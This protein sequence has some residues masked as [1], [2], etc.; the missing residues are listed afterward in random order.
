MSTDRPTP[1]MPS[2]P[3]VLQTIEQATQRVVTSDDFVTRLAQAIVAQQRSLPVNTAYSELGVARSSHH[4]DFGS[5]VVC[6]PQPTIHGHLLVL[7][8]VPVQHGLNVLLTLHEIQPADDEPRAEGV[9]LQRY[10]QSLV[11]DERA[12]DLTSRRYFDF[13]SFAPVEAQALREELSRQLQT[14]S[15]TR[16][17]FLYVNVLQKPSAVH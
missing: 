4:S 15:F 11:I 17:V 12:G 14:L 1:E 7:T 13:E 3:S 2:S 9:D 16:G 8:Q 5:C 6:P 10:T